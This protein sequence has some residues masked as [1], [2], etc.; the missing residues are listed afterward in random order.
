MLTT[1]LNGMSGVFGFVVNSVTA[2]W[3][4]FLSQPVLM[5]VLAIWILGK[6]IDLFDLLKG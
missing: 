2:L 5:A 6:V 4:L 1:F 3:T